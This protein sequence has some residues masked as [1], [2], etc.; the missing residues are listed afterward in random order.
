MFA[1]LV[2]FYWCVTAKR[3]LHVA[4]NISMSYADIKDVL[5]IIRIALF[6][7]QV[8]VNA[9]YTNT[10]LLKKHLTNIYVLKM[11]LTN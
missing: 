10:L 2:A 11:L 7:S 8:Y 5:D 1:H 3:D 6:W 4:A 9:Y